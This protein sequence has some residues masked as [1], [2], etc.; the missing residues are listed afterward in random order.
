MP[1]GLVSN[2]HNV[3]LGAAKATATATATERG[4]GCGE[5]RGGAGAC[6]YLRQQ[7]DPEHGLRR[8]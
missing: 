1:I 5:S 6:S 4:G 3:H 8:C 7:R 2:R